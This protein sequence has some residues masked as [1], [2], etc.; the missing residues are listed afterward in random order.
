MSMEIAVS[1]AWSIAELRRYRQTRFPWT[2]FVPL[3]LFL[4]LA[5]IALAPEALLPETA[6][7]R[8]L[9]MMA[10]LFQFR[11]A[12]DLADRQRDRADHPERLLVQADVLPFLVLLGLLAAGNTCLTA[13]L[14]PW[15]RWV[16]FLALNA[17]LF[18]WYALRLPLLLASFGVLLKYAALVYLLSNPGAMRAPA[19]GVL[20]LVSACF[21]AHEILHDKRL[22]SVPGI[23]GWLALFLLAMPAAAVLPVFHATNTTWWF[24]VWLGPGSAI[25]AL[26]FYRHNRRYEPGGWPYAIFLVTSVWII[27]SYLV[28]G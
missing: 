21:L 6:L 28:P 16:E 7:R 19:I 26:L 2:R 11:L 18:L 9:L 13:W 1:F 4:T 3:A 23:G 14:L 25:L 22:W 12:D 24:L 20:A 27:C 5:S 10:W 8:L 17:F 15:P